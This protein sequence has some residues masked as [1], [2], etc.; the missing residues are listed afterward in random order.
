MKRL[1]LAALLFTL[2]ACGATDAPNA[3]HDSIQASYSTVGTIKPR[4]MLSCP[5]R[6]SVTGDTWQEAGA[7]MDLHLDLIQGWPEGK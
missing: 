7:M 3:T 2:T 6:F 4:P 5:C 1:T